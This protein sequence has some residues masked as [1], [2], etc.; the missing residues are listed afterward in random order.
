MNWDAIM[1]DPGGALLSLLVLWLLFV[2][3]R[4]IDAL[5]RGAR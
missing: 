5:L 4:G 1:A 2:I 3:V